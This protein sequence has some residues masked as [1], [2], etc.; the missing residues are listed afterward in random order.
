[1]SFCDLS[2]HLPSFALSVQKSIAAED[3]TVF[4][5]SRAGGG[6]SSCSSCSE[7]Q[8]HQ[9]SSAAVGEERSLDYARGA[10]KN[11]NAPKI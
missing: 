11:I 7:K 4:I 5:E 9:S 3:L 8:V 1:M 2:V 10:A 6:C